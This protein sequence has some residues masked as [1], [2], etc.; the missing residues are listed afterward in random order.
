[1]LRFLSRRAIGAFIAVLGV[2]TVV[3]L[4]L[5]LNSDP[6]ALL[7]PQ[8]A[9]EADYQRMREALGL[10]D[11]LPVQYVTYLAHLAAGDFGRSLRYGEPALGVV[12][13]RVPA[14]AM[15]AFVAFALAVA[16]G[17]PLG[18]V[19]AA[20]R[21]SSIDRVVSGISFLGQAVPVFWLGPILII[22]VAVQLRWLPTSG[23]GDISHVVLPAVTLAVQPM[24]QFTRITRSEM[25]DALSQDYVQTARA[26]GPI[27]NGRSAAPRLEERRHRD[28]HVHG[29]EPRHASERSNYHRDHLWLAGRRAIDDS[30]PSVF[31]T[32]RW[33]KRPR[34]LSQR[35]S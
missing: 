4:I 22:L 32:S 25:L 2:T 26:R 3:F 9:T 24:A 17:V 23:G 21:G 20:Y 11:P 13:E 19:A 18:I 7:M 31:A 28:C 1:M 5:H 30:A 14:T 6:A 12:I 10:N 34:W 16:V 29:T 8:N 27:R 15:L 35:S 33:C